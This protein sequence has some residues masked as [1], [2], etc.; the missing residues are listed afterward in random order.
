ME[1][2]HI[3]HLLILLIL[4]TE[5]VTGRHKGVYDKDDLLLTIGSLA[6]T[7]LV[8]SPLAAGLVALVMVT[9]LP[10]FTGSMSETPIWMALLGMV[11]LGDFLFYWVHRAA[12]NPAKFPFL[13]KLHAT[14]HTATF[15]NVSLMARINVFWVFFQPY[16][17]VS[18]LA[19]YLGMT[20]AAVY[21]FTGMMAWNAFTHTNF[22][23]DDGIRNNLPKG[24]A[25]VQAIEWVFITPRLHH[26]HHGYGKDGKAFRNYCTMLSIYDRMFGTLFIPEG[27]PAKY[28]IIGRNNKNTS[29]WEQLAY[30][31]FKT[32]KKEVVPVQE[33]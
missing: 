28:G 13:Y 11:L 6:I 32:R 1:I 7:R 22:R 14:H 12:H 5:I 18:G 8:M 21:F 10:G 31:I 27:R 2:T 30:P 25:I 24:D 33:A 16:L 17:W 3:I 9:V 29:L 23:W 15:M 19:V 26:T 20:E 4:A